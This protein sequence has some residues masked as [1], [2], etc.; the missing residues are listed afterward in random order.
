MPFVVD[1]SVVVAWH[2]SSQATP[3]SDAVLNALVVEAGH[4]PAL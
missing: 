4:V 3:C 1:N 2:L